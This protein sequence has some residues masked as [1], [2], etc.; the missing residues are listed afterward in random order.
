MLSI[1]AS[2]GVIFRNSFLEIWW[3]GT[4]LV[5]SDPERDAYQGGNYTIEIAHD[6]L[7]SKCRQEMFMTSDLYNPAID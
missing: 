1:V 3:N 4:V 2:I 6:I 7:G 5:R